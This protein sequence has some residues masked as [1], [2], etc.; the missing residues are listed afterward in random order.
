MRDIVITL[1]VGLVIAVLALGTLGQ[2]GLR[3][4]GVDPRDTLTA[5]DRVRY[6]SMGT[7]V[8]FTA[9]AATASLTIALSLIFSPSRWLEFLPAGIIWG[10]IVL[11]FDRWIVSSV[12]YGGLSGTERTA[13]QAL[14]IG[15][16]LVHFLVR[17]IM[18]ALVGLVISE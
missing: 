15:S 14:R 18:A 12:D 7:V 10:S 11:S 4:A 17:F 13:G 5:P 3:V 8:L 1:G 9:L 2:V 16:K 6:T